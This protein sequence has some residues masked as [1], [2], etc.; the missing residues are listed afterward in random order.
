MLSLDIFLFQKVYFE[1]PGWT[2]T[3]ILSPHYNQGV[4]LHIPCYIYIYYG[5]MAIL[6]FWFSL[7]SLQILQ[8]QDSVSLL[9]WPQHFCSVW[10]I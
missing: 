1:P 4:P 3:P 9:S 7:I 10:L 5:E 6:P 8:E 2:N